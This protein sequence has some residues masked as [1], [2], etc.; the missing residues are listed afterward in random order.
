[1][2]N[3]VL[4]KVLNDIQY[5]WQCAKQYL[6]YALNNDSHF[7]YI[8]VLNCVALIVAS[9]LRITRVLITN[10]LLFSLHDD[11]RC[12]VLILLIPLRLKK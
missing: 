9:M 8:A 6:N 2:L 12:D 4:V 5:V 7:N 10:T 11:C 1:M 3:N